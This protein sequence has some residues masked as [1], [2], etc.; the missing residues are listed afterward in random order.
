MPDG[1][2]RFLILDGRGPGS[3]GVRI[4]VDREFKNFDAGIGYTVA[5]GQEFSPRSAANE[6]S[7]AEQM[8]QRQLHVV[9]ARIKTDLDITNTQLTAVYRWVSPFA[10]A[11]IDP[12]QT[13]VEYNDPTL[14]ITVAQNLPTWGMFPGKVQAILDAR[15]LLEQSANGHTTQISISPRFVKGGIN[16]RF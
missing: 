13:N 2:R 9:T 7:I 8:T 15:N 4:F 14:S 11:P 1:S 16:I 12:Y 3:N 5:T 10:A 6:S